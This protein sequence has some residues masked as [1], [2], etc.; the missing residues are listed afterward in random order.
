MNIHRAI[1]LVAVA[2][3]VAATPGCGYDPITAI[4]RRGHALDHVGQ[5]PTGPAGQPESVNGAPGSPSEVQTTSGVSPRSG[6][7]SSDQTSAAPGTTR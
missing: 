3:S 5:Y 2:S 4:D 7:R 1:A 6:L